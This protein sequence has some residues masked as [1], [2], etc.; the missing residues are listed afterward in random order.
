MERMVKLTFCVR[1]LPHLSLH[2]FQRYWLG[3][4]GPLV[5]ERA[6]ALKIKRYV[7]MHRVDMPANDAMRASRD[8]A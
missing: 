5:K 6:V 7:Q 4:H 3:N 1:K 2:E 8:T